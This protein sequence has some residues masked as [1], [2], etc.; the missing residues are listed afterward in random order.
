MRFITSSKGY[1]KV[2]QNNRKFYGR[3]FNFLVQR[4]PE[5]ELISVGIVASRK[6]GNAVT[7]NLVKRR[8]KAFLREQQ[9]WL[10]GGKN[11]V[12]IAKQSASQ[13]DWTAVSQDLTDL[14]KQALL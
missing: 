13:A 14:F 11:I 9:V 6:V 1:N 4:E 5:E 10:T 2:Y 12:I 7:R 3:L 8:V